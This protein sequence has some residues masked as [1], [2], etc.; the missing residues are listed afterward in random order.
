MDPTG[1][2]WIWVLRD[3]PLGKLVVLFHYDKSRGGKVARELLEGFSGRYY[4]CDGYAGQK[5]GGGNTDVTVLGC[6][7]H[8]RVSLSQP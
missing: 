8:A 4:Q 7:E 1:D 2:K 6:M 3:G 5:I